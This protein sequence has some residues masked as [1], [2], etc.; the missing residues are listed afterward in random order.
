MCLEDHEGLR[1]AQWEPTLWERARIWFGFLWHQKLGFSGFSRRSLVDLLL[2]ML[3]GLSRVGLAISPLALRWWERQLDANVARIAVTITACL[4]AYIYF[5]DS[6][7]KRRRKIKAIAEHEARSLNLR[8][9]IIE[10]IAASHRIVEDEYVGKIY[11]C[12][13]DAIESEVRM[14]A[15][16]LDARY[17]N[18]SLLLFDENA[19][20]VWV[21]VRW[22]NRRRVGS[23]FKRKSK[24]TMAYWVARANLAYRAVPDL[25]WKQNEAFR[26]RGLAE[27][28][29]PYRSVLFLPI[30][31]DR[32]EDRQTVSYGIIAIDSSK[33]Y[34]FTHR[35]AREYEMRVNPFL[36]VLAMLLRQ[37]GSPFPHSEAGHAN[38][39]GGGAQG[40][41]SSDLN[42][43]EARR[44]VGGEDSASVPRNESGRD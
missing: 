24:E 26:G 35:N 39:I 5:H 32:P 15:G 40:C 37:T 17:F 27:N 43:R 21:E 44:P 7:L 28:D 6:L 18:C 12:I 4:T 1:W 10:Y 11:K 19:E 25:K 16:D 22:D 3:S 33:P 31:Y 14:I 8:S 13:V 34:Q 20:S 38:A 36:S 42:R 41:R 2:N 30:F 9:R 29:Q 23:Q